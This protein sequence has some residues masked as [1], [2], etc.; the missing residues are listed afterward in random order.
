MKENHELYLG[1][2]KDIKYRTSVID[3]LF[4]D[5]SGVNL[6]ITVLESACLQLRKILEQIAFGSLVSNVKLYSQE[7]AKFE[8]FWNAEYLLKDMAKVNPKYFPIPISQDKSDVKGVKSQFN[9]KSDDTYL[10][11]VEF[12]KVYKKCGAIL[13]ARNPFGSKVSLEFYKKNIPI[14]RQKIIN[15]LNSHEVHFVGDKN[16]YLFQMGAINE[17]PSFTCF[18]PMQENT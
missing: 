8:K 11:P 15:L 13:H 2:L 1:I 5:A 14:W 7:Y 10:N 4:S 12:V 9:I 16:L 3:R 6:E 18:E 17:P